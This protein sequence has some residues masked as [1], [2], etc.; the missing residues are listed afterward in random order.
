M[1]MQETVVSGT[2]DIRDDVDCVPLIRQNN[3]TCFILYWILIGF[4]KLMASIPGVLIDNNK[5]YKSYC[6]SKT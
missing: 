4:C 2:T 6:I 1:H 3:S 5:Q